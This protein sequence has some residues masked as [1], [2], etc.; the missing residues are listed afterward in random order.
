VRHRSEA[1]AT[2][3]VQLDLI[4]HPRALEIYIYIHCRS[5]VEVNNCNDS[6]QL[7]SS[8]ARL[9]STK[10][11]QTYLC[12]RGNCGCSD[13]SPFWFDWHSA[14]LECRSDSCI[15]AP[16]RRARWIRKENDGENDENMHVVW[17]EHQIP[18][19]SCDQYPQAHQQLQQPAVENW[20]STL[21]LQR[22][23]A[24]RAMAQEQ[25]GSNKGK[26]GDRGTADS[27]GGELGERRR[28]RRGRFGSTSCLPAGFMQ[29]DDGCL[30][31]SG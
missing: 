11:F 30:A 20:V 24:T 7:A 17:A 14:A 12:I 25:E 10:E 1:V 2:T 6:E 26:V 19:P 16:T 28:R 23:P 18:V 31:V 3:E 13:V 27:V 5:L 9:T 4:S 15:A 21:N 29:S 22:P 8:S